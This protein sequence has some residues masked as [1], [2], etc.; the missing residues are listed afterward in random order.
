VA[1]LGASNAEAER[2]VGVFFRGFG[3]SV[4][5][6]GMD[7]LEAHLVGVYGG[8]MARPF[9]TAVFNWTDQSAAFAFVGGFGDVDCVIL[10]GHSF[11]ANSAVEFATN[12]LE[13]AG[14]PV[15]RLF[16]FDSVG[17]NGGVLPANVVAGFNYHQVSTGAFEPQGVS[18][19]QGATNVYVE[20][21]YGV[22]DADI[23]H[24]EID[25]PLFE[26]SE[27]GYAALFG[28]QPDLYAR[29]EGHLAPLFELPAVPGLGPFGAALLFF[30]LAACSLG[31]FGLRRRS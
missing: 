28:I 2:C 20:Q 5:S 24:T 7:N 16:Q 10:A 26:R 19:V 15:D 30:A 29:V 23:T 22:S 27:S 11:G 6:S 31:A 1:L 12:F 8:N 3:A 14:I 25:C 4:G 18:T 13:P 17:P 9:S 21:D